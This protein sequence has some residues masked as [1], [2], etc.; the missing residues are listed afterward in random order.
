MTAEEELARHSLQGLI[1]VMSDEMARCDVS[2]FRMDDSH[3]V[4]LLVLLANALDAL[5]ASS[6]AWSPSSSSSSAS[7]SSAAGGGESSRNGSNGVVTDPWGFVGAPALRAELV[8]HDHELGIMQQAA[9]PHVAQ[10]VRSGAPAGASLDPNAEFV[11]QLYGPAM[12]SMQLLAMRFTAHKLV[13]VVTLEIS[14]LRNEYTPHI[15]VQVQDTLY[16]TRSLKSTRRFARSPGHNQIASETAAWRDR[17]TRIQAAE[18]KPIGQQ[19]SSR[20]NGG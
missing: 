7:S 3:L 13:H 12:D 8:R 9:G 17:S 1:T 15:E 6:S 19:F 11:R 2:S 18:S 16:V 4:D 20:H 10:F 14:T 5:I